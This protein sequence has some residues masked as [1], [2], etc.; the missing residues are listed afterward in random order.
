[1]QA[2]VSDR[3]PNLRVLD[4]QRL[5]ELGGRPRSREENLEFNEILMR[6]HFSREYFEKRLWEK[7]SRHVTQV[8]AHRGR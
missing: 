8:L 2:I 1:M 7:R 3:G 5:M 6:G 4:K